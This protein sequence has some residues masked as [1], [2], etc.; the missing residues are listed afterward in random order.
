MGKNKHTNSTVAF[1]ELKVNG[2]NT[3]SQ[4]AGNWGCNH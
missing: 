4:A 2:M 3:E 1:K